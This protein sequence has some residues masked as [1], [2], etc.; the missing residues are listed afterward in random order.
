MVV[1]DWID[2]IEFGLEASIGLMT[3]FDRP[4]GVGMATGSSTVLV[5]LKRFI[6]IHLGT[7]ASLQ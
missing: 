4:V 2:S 1:V 3:G 6:N 7:M 5:G